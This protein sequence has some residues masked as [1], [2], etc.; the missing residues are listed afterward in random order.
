MLQPHPWVHRHCSMVEE[1]LQGPQ[2]TTGVTTSSINNKWLEFY[3]QNITICHSINLWTLRAS[4]IP[5]S[6]LWKGDNTNKPTLEWQPHPTM[7]TPPWFLEYPNPRV[8][9]GG[10]GTMIYHLLLWYFDL[11]LHVHSVVRS[12]YFLSSLMSVCLEY[13]NDRFVVSLILLSYEVI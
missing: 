3:M 1:I 8:K 9:E 10:G 7:A 4:L 11:D 5:F 6:F 13:S 12:L 2:V